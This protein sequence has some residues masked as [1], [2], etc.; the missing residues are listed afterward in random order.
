MKKLLIALYCGVACHC[1]LAE[2]LTFHGRLVTPPICTINNNQTIEVPFDEVDIDEINGA[3]FAKEVPYTIT[4]DSS[5]RFSSMS[6]TLTLLGTPVD[7]D[8]AAVETTVNGLGIQLRQ[9]DSAFTVGST[10]TIDEQAK[11]TIKAVPVKKTGVALQEGAFEGW[12]T[13]QVDYQ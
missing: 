2:N 12:A 10:I 13:L 9:N 6:M 11:P 4:C 8:N 5:V 1:A 3:N 7:F